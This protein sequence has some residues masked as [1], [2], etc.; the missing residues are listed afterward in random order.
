MKKINSYNGNAFEFHKEMVNDKHTGAVKTRLKTYEVNVS[1]QYSLF[2][3]KFLENKLESLN[4]FGYKYSAK[5]DL[6]SLYSS[7]KARIIKL[8]NELTTTIDGRDDSTCP[9]C[10]IGEVN[11]LDH[12]IPKSLYAEFSVNP[13]NL[14]PCCSLC[15]SK[16]LDIWLE[17]GKRKFLN[18]YVDDIPSEQYLFVNL[19]FSDDDFDYNY[20]VDNRNQIDA[21]LFELIKSHYD[22][23]GLT[24]RFKAKSNN[25]VS[26]LEREIRKYIRLLQV[27]IIKELIL[28]EIIEEKQ[29]FGNNY[30]KSILKQ[31]L[32][33]SQDFMDRFIQ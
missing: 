3:T 17:V 6:V 16:K 19:S 21:D 14:V 33:N 5:S 10:T 32:V 29:L 30:W 22:R 24:N 11:S 27:D 28:E 8:K 25:V 23:L 12:Y 20:I 31:T 15:N 26:E 7:Q 2:E 9:F 13:K 1:A 18:L 4:S